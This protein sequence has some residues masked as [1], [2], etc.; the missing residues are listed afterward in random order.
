[1]HP[2]WLTAIPSINIIVYINT[3]I[4]TNLLCFEIITI[5]HFYFSSF[6]A[7]DYTISWYG[8]EL[9]NVNLEFNLNVFLLDNGRRNKKMKYSISSSHLSSCLHFPPLLI[10]T[11]GI[12]LYHIT[13][14]YIAAYHIT[15]HYITSLSSPLFSYLILGIQKKANSSQIFVRYTQYLARNMTINSS[16]LRSSRK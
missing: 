14:H 1:M 10:S 9:S 12:T 7:I 6:R 15:S 4:S 5:E 11:L 2:S 13:L 3:I 16:E 8:M